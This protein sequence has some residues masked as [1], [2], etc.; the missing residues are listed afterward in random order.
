MVGLTLIAGAASAN[1]V[2]DATLFGLY[3]PLGLY[4]DAEIGR[5]TINQTQIR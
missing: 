4:I 1:A 2:A 5:S 3:N